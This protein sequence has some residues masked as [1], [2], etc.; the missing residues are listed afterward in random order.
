MRTWKY[1]LCF[2]EKG[3]ARVDTA[4]EHSS[5]TMNDGREDV[6]AFQKTLHCH[7]EHIH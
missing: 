7:P 3:M 6:E 5:L 4:A 2:L 1:W